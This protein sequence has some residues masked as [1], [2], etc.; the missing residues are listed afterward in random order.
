[1]QNLN[2]VSCGKEPNSFLV[3]PGLEAAAHQLLIILLGLHAV[4]NKRDLGAH[5]NYGAG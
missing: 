1:M 5:I 2:C 3:A 4:F